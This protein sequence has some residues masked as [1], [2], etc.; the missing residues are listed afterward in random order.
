MMQCNAASSKPK[1]ILKVILLWIVIELHEENTKLLYMLDATPCTPRSY[2]KYSKTLNYLL[3]T[4]VLE[5]QICSVQRTHLTT[6]TNTH[7]QYLQNEKK[8]IK[9]K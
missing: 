7:T 4:E 2:V 3:P 5:L 1:F 6:F 8:I 9:E